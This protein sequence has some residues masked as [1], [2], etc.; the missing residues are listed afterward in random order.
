MATFKE[1][2]NEAMQIRD[3][4]AA[5]LSRASGVAEVSI[6]H[7]RKGTYKATQEKLDLIATAL[8]VSI[9]WLMGVTDTFGPRFDYGLEPIPHTKQIPV[10]GSIACGDPVLAVQTADEMTDAPDFVRCDFALYCK[11]DSMINARIFDGD[12]V[13]IR[14]QDTVEDG[15]IAAV[16]IDDEATL[17]RVKKYDDRLALLPE[18]P[19]YKPIVLYGDDAKTVQILGKAVAFTSRVL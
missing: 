2:L 1:R 16:L 14:R 19:M 13:Y 5:E 12:L 17:K 8:N 7:Y 15:E 3:I 11:G 18:N 10:L 4:T 9:P 6:S